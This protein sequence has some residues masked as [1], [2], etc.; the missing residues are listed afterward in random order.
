MHRSTRRVRLLAAALAWHLCLLACAAAAQPDA[1][2]GT[3]L[4]TVSGDLAAQ[5]RAGIDKFVTRATEESPANRAAHWQRDYSSPAAY[6]ASVAPNRARFCRI[7]GLADERL[8]CRHLELVAT[9]ESPALL[10]ENE[11][12]RVLAVRWPVLPGVYGEGLL[13]QPNLPPLARIVAIPDADHTPEMLAG[14]SAGIPP[15]EQFARRLA[16]LGCLVV[17]PTLIDRQDTWSGTPAI[18]M[19]NQ[20]HREWIYRQAF[21]FGRHIIGYEVQKILSAVDWFASQNNSAA[22][23]MGVAGYGEGGLLA[24]YAAAADTRIDAALVSGY[25]QPRQ[26]LWNEPLYRNVWGLLDEFGDAEIAS[27][28]APRR[29]VVEHSLGPNVPSPPMP[30][31]GRRAVAAPGVLQSP[32]LEGSLHEMLRARSL[33]QQLPDLLPTLKIIIGDAGEAIGPGSPAAIAAFCQRLGLPD[34]ACAAAGSASPAQPPAFGKL[35]NAQLP[36]ASERQQRQVRQLVDYTQSL[37]VR[38]ETDRVNFWKA[39]ASVTPDNWQQA[40]RPY[41]DYLWD[42]VLGRFPPA[43]LP[44]HPR[45]R[46]IHDEPAFVGYEV[47]LDVWPDVFCWGILLVPRDIA[48]DERRPVVVCQHGL[49]GQPADVITRDEH[50]PAF[51]SYKGFAAQL[52]E[53][54]FVTYC[55]HN[56]YRGGNEFRQLQRKLYPL[57]KTMFSVILAQHERHL[58]WL[59]ALPFVDAGRIGFYG[60]SY[61]GFTAIRVPPLLDRYAL[62]I[63]SAEFND[64]VRKKVSIDHPYSYPFHNTYEVFEFNLAST[65]GYGEMASLMAPRP[66]MVERGHSDGVGPDEWV[67]SEYAKVRRHYARLGMP[68]RTE[69]EYFSG[70]HTIHGVGTFRFLHRHLDWPDK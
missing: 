3:E 38:S 4:L 62:S 70:P 9:T 32:A 59:A 6:E 22:A 19:T 55:P 26:Q 16:E 60:L 18:A 20:T 67:A 51:A 12:Y 65:F 47:M 29:L 54:G 21:E 15:E 33:L 14:L 13:L 1:L 36:D 46:K 27:L 66:Y 23:P 57:K 10:A 30:L 25:F 48:P 35:T 34:A 50:D 52:A 31:A 43:T 61:G 8:P 64:M 40:F 28:I 11:T 53:R 41:K 69:I 24:F 5:M 39:A 49:E 44:V 42:E 2:P 45:T 37:I 56:F 68:E 63:H 7:I 17:V 58:D